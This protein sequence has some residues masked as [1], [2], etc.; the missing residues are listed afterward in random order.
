MSLTSLPN[1]HCRKATAIVLAIFYFFLVGI[2]LEYPHSL[3]QI[4]CCF[5]SRFYCYY[6]GRRGTP[7]MF[8][9]IIP[10]SL[11]F[12][13]RLVWRSSTCFVTLPFVFSFLSWSCALIF[14]AKC[15]ILPFIFNDLPFIS[16]FLN[17]AA[18]KKRRPFFFFSLLLWCF[19]CWSIRMAAT[20]V[21]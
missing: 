1:G 6:Y 20:V 12:S 3:Q 19:C 7:C 11:D 9:Y 2:T 10:V 15:H 5:L 18:K 13:F 14:W 16:P 8:K 4:C 17:W 21:S